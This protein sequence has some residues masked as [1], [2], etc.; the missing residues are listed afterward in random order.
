[1]V[2]SSNTLRQQSNCERRLPSHL[3]PY[4]V[5]H[6]HTCF[7]SHCPS[8]ERRFE[9]FEARQPCLWYPPHADSLVVPFQ[10]CHSIVE[11]PQCDGNRCESKKGSPTLLVLPMWRTGAYGQGLPSSFRRSLHDHRRTKRLCPTGIRWLRRQGRR[12]RSL[13]RRRRGL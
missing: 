8:F 4:E 12:V 10:S 2:R 11:G 1:M 5:P 7:K 6:L 3:S 9:S 13:R